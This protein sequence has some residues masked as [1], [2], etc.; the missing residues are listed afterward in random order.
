MYLR[1]SQF[2]DKQEMETL[3]FVYLFLD[4]LYWSDLLQA[5]QNAI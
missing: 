3:L 2:P 5:V 1:N 4:L